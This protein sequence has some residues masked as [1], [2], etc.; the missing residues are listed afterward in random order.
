M[1]LH[2]LPCRIC[3]EDFYWEMGMGDICDD[4]LKHEEK[5]EKYLIDFTNFIPE[6]QEETLRL[7]V[8]SNGSAG[9]PCDYTFKFKDKEFFLNEWEF[10]AMCEIISRKVDED[11][12]SEIEV[13]Q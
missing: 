4:C 2:T 1:K 12:L 9:S 7:L 8:D 13:S 11:N 6:E 10:E 5:N 3:K